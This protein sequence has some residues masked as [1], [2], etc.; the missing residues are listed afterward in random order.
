VSPESLQAVMSP[1]HVAAGVWICCFQVGFRTWEWKKRRRGRS[2]GSPAL[3]AVCSGGDLRAAPWPSWRWWAE[4]IHSLSGYLESSFSS[5]ACPGA[6]IPLWGMTPATAVGKT[7][8]KGASE[9]GTPEGP[10]FCRRPR[11]ESLTVSLL[12]TRVFSSPQL[13]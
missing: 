11:K 12:S 8:R 2:G 3:C 7:Q 6:G 5:P 1:Y 4:E 10:G 13:E 9:R